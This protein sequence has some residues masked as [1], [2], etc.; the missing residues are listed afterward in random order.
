M[1]FLQ[2]TQ[3][4]GPSMTQEFLRQPTRPALS[5][6]SSRSFRSWA[7]RRGVQCFLHFGERVV[8]HSCK[9]LF[10]AVLSGWL[11]LFQFLLGQ[12]LPGHPRQVSWSSGFTFIEYE[13]DAH[14][15]RIA[16]HPHPFGFHPIS[17]VQLSPK[18]IHPFAV[19]LGLLPLGPT[20]L[21]LN[22]LCWD[23]SYPSC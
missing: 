10:T 11:V 16:S 20:I 22:I 12:G 14:G 3:G 5:G 1:N 19:P 8:S 7:T 21:C 6:S 9:S 15:H 13:Y 23:L 18:P 4:G 17:F 2:D